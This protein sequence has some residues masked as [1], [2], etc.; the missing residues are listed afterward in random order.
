[1]DKDKYNFTT[2]DIKAALI[3]FKDD[4]V[5]L[6]KD[7]A[8][9]ET[10]LQSVEAKLAKFPK[11]GHMLADLPVLISMAR[12]YVMKKYT[13]IPTSTVAAVIAVMIYFVT[14]VDLIPDFIPVVGLIDD[15]AALAFVVAMMRDDLD[16]YV[17]WQK[18]NGAR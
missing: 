2:E 17:E 4:A 9:V 11:I 12:A 14:P 7:D 13:A 1:M 15:A 5:E 18:E 3:K 6:L 10:F 16:A 8:K